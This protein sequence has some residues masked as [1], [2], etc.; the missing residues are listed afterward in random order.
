M[1]YLSVTEINSHVGHSERLFAAEKEQ[2]AGLPFSVFYRSTALDL[3]AGV[4]RKDDPVHEVAELNESAAVEM[5]DRVAAP[6]VRSSGKAAG[7]RSDFACAEGPSGLVFGGKSASALGPG[8]E[9]HDLMLK[10]PALATVGEKDFHPAVLPASS[11]THYVS[12][13]EIT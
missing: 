9:I 7:K 13:R 1:N 6:H 5:L 8:A 12:H 4:A 3:L 11:L 10:Y 2:V